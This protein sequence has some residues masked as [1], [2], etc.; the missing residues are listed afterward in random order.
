M[1]QRS[2]PAAANDAPG[3]HRRLQALAAERGVQI[4]SA[5]PSLRPPAQLPQYATA[6]HFVQA[7]KLLANAR[8]NSGKKDPSKKLANRF[9]SQSKKERLDRAEN[10]EFSD[11]ERGM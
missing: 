7:T 5:K 1:D 9:K 11:G 3:R 10:W 4:L 8:R 6:E 2:L